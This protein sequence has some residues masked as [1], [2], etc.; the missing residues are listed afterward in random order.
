MKAWHMLLF[1]LFFLALA[2]VGLAATPITDCTTIDSPGTYY[3]ANDIYT[4]GVFECIGITSDNVVLDCQGHIID[5]NFSSSYGIDVMGA[6]VTIKNCIVNGCFYGIYIDSS[7]N[8]Q[9]LNAYINGSG[10]AGLAMMSSSNVYVINS[11]INESFVFD[12]DVSGTEEAHCNNYFENV[13][14]SGGLPIKYYNYSVNLSGEVLSE[15]VLCNADY[16]SISN[17]TI[18]GSPTLDNNGIYA[19]FTDSAVFS[20]INSSNN[21]YGIYLLRS[22]NNQIINS[23]LSE[24]YMDLEVRPTTESHCNNYVESVVGY[25]GLPIKY[26]NHSVSLSNEVLAELVL[27]NADYS[28]ITNITIT[29]S[30]TKKT[31]ALEAYFTDNSNFYQINSSS[32]REG[33]YVRGN[34]NTIVDCTADNNKEINI[35]IAGDYNMV[36][37]SEATGSVWCILVYKNNNTVE[38]SVAKNCLYGIYVGFGNENTIRNN[39]VEN[40]TYGI[41]MVYTQSNVI[42]NNLLNNTNN[43][44][45]EWGTYQN[46]WNTTKHEGTNI[47]GGPY[48]GGNY[49]GKPDGTGFSDSCAD[50]DKDGICDEPYALAADNTDYLPLAKPIKAEAGYPSLKESLG[51]WHGVLVILIVLGALSWGLSLLKREISVRALISA[52]LI[53]I[54]ALLIVSML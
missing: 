9:V 47:V 27:C 14:G 20:E 3:L 18:T 31:N 4:Q 44:N 34:N 38:D 1:F 6:N 5:G 40:N 24:N 26:F 49:W 25:G 29:G 28:N 39:I 37:G 11:T 36:D 51:V 41:G 48:I 35:Y 30:P 46:Y 17:I 12:V 52:A 19:V 8:V 10:E 7:S 13:T 23:T 22:A 54:A 42:Y 32:N 53:L 15:L 45:F 16:S 43:I 33:I 2:R 50:S 21:F